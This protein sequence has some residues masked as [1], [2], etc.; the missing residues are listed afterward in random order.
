MAI[1]TG[2][3][4]PAKLAAANEIDPRHIRSRTGGIMT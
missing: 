2:I 4:L 1:G 3:E